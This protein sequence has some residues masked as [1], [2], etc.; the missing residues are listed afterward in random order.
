[1]TSDQA[2][3]FLARVKKSVSVA[4]FT[5]QFGPLTNALP[6]G[7]S[8]EVTS[9]GKPHGR[10]IREGRRRAKWRFDL[11]QRVAAL[12]YP[13]SEGQKLIEAILADA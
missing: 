5:K 6:P 12:D 2:S 7:E 3:D 1:M 8:I 9:R 11:G 4:E 10:Y 13:E